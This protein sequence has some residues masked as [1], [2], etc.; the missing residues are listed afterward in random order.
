MASPEARG[1]RGN[2]MLE[3]FPKEARQHLEVIEEQHKSNK[4]LIEADQ[5]PEWLYFPHRGAVVSLTRSSASGATVEVGIVGW[6]GIVS[7][8]ALLSPKASGANAVV[9]IAGSTSRVRLREMRELLD[10]DSDV[11]ECL[12]L[13]AGTFL[14]QVSQHVVCNRLHSIEERLA[15]WLLAVSERIDSEEIALTHDFLSHMIG[16]RRSGVT[17]AIGALTL[18]GL[19]RHSRNSIWITDREGL[20]DRTC[21]CYGV[22]AEAMQPLLD[23]LG[24]A[25][26]PPKRKRA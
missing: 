14:A 11:R 1:P 25:E 23:R 15:K 9:Q 6:E 8:H 4:L 20:E 2:A 12:L 24:E 10:G 21:E 18:D 17:I 5:I 26:R 3:A 16:I 7:L 19:I 22:I 13:F